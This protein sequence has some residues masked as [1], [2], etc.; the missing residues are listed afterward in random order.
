M[1][2]QNEINRKNNVFFLLRESISLLP[3]FIPIAIHDIFSFKEKSAPIV[4]CPL[5]TIESPIYLFLKGQRMLSF[6][7]IRI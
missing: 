3:Q 7:F 6:T 4:I 5:L 2:K 1:T